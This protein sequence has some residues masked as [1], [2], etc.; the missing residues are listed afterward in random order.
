MGRDERKPAAALR[1]SSRTARARRLAQ[2]T[3]VA[4]IR[5]SPFVTP[6]KLLVLYPIVC[7]R[8]LR[9]DPAPTGEA[10]R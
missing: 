6:E 2:A 3:G 4:P 7:C 10:G 8:S 1:A 5:R 9:A